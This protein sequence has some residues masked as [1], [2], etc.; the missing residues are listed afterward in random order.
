MPLAFLKSLA[1]TLSRHP[2][3]SR[4]GVGT[5]VLSG[6]SLCVGYVK[7]N[8]KPQRPE[9]SSWKKNIIFAPPSG[10]W[11]DNAWYDLQL[12]RRLPLA[13]QAVRE[14]V[15]ALPPL[16]G[17]RVADL[18]SG[19]GRSALAVAAA[20]P[21]AQLTLLD[22]DEDR[23]ATALL[24]LKQQASAAAA[25]AINASSLGQARFIPVAVAA[26][27][28]ALPGS[29][30]EDGGPYDCVVALQAI[31]HIVAPPVHYAAKLGLSAV[32]SE[33]EIV[34]GYAAMFN[35]I[36][37]SLA[38]GGHIF[39]GDHVV[40]KHPGVYSHCR[41]LEEAGFVDVDVAWR[42]NDWFVIGARRPC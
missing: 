34:S 3:L 32:Q 33:E 13:A 4:C 19:S 11:S 16:S 26:K 30:I 7:A 6:G 22:A 2:N 8:E 40:H 18:G 36:F 25:T 12:E 41:L 37:S 42:Q 20:Y 10:F 27:K 23:G 14:M 28:D 17:K 5:I 21:E 29:S 38:P 31:R 9:E 1:G 15:W 39:I 24:R 35:G